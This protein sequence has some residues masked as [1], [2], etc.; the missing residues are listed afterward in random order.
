MSEVK[1]DKLSPRDP[2][3]SRLNDARL[4]STIPIQA[5]DYRNQGRKP[6]SKITKPVQ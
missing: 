3:V 2:I 4:V 5:G 1:T 6:S